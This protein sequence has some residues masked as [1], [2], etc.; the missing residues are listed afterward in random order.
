VKLHEAPCRAYGR[1]RTETCRNYP[2]CWC[3]TGTTDEQRESFGA[4]VSALKLSDKQLRDA[5]FAYRLLVLNIDH[6]LT[7]TRLSE[8]VRIPFKVRDAIFAL[9]AEQGVLARDERRRWSVVRC[10]PVN[11]GDAL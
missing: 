2:S 10:L 9:L 11:G 3:I 7:V 8:F 4:R 6:G 1:N 5:F